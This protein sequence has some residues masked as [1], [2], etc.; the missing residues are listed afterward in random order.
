[1]VCGKYVKTFKEATHALPDGMHMNADY[2]FKLP[3]IIAIEGNNVRIK[4]SGQEKT[5]TII[6]RSGQEYGYI[7]QSSSY[8]RMFGGKPTRFKMCPF[9]DENTEIPTPPEAV[10]DKDA[11][12]DKGV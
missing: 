2:P 8:E 12:A 3:S 9:K 10:A 1:M 4:G 6:K 7:E 5:F 11:V